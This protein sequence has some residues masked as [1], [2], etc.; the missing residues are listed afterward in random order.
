VFCD[1]LVI[2]HSAKMDERS[3]IAIHTEA[4]GRSEEAELTTRLLAGNVNTISLIAACEN[5]P[6]GHILL[7]E[8]EAPV[9]SMALAPLSVVKKYRELHIGSRLVKQAIEEARRAGYQAI[10][11]LGDTRY[12]ERFGFSGESAAPFDCAYQ[13]PHFMALALAPGVLNNCRGKIVYPH[14]FSN[15]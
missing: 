3:I 14:A 13:G 6:I 15:V 9:K 12:Y 4:F 5:I 2:R 8:I 10:F 1:Q 7:S 11:V